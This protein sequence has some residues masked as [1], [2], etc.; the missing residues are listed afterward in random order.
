MLDRSSNNL[1][2]FRGQARRACDLSVKQL[3]YWAGLGMV[4]VENL[5]VPAQHLHLQVKI[6]ASA[7]NEN[8][9]ATACLGEGEDIFCY[10]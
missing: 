7:E 1:L 9:I 4:V 8:T 10:L 2:F 6:R 3:E 5:R